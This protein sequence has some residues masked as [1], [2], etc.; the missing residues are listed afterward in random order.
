MS[1]DIRFEAQRKLHIPY[2]KIIEESAA[3]TL[4]KEGCPFPYALSVCIVDQEEMA[5]INE[6]FRG[7]AKTTDVLSFPFLSF[8]NPADFKEAAKEPGA[9]HPETGELMLGDIILSADHIIDQAREYG[10]TRRRELAFLVV[11]SVLHLI[12]YD[13]ME[14]ADRLLMEERQKRILDGGGFKR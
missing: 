6:E 7:L 1:L 5:S 10:H 13:H 2:K 14:E 9:F 8:P 11:H 3:L 4:L 12:G